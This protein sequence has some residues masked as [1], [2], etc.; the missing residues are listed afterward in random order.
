MKLSQRIRRMECQLAE[1]ACSHCDEIERLI[2][3]RGKE[4]APVSSRQC[5][6]C[7][8]VWP[9]PIIRIVEDS[10]LLE[11]LDYIR[12]HLGEVFG[13]ERLIAVSGTSRR[14]LEFAFFRELACSP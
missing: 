8:R 9:C 6:H 10:R 13:V 1:Q 3:V 11:A 12:D 7:G 2:I 4:E 5:A 14:A